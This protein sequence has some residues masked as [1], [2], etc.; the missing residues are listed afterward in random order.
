M[1]ILRWSPPLP[2][3][4]R[5]ALEDDIVDVVGIEQGQS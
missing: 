1:V 4:V 5:V 3:P 2:P